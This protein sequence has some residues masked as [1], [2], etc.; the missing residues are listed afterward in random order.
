MAP[1]HR[2]VTYKLYP[3]PGQA[4]GDRA[5]L[6]PAPGLVQRGAGGADRGIPQGGQVDRL[7]RPVQIRD[8]IRRD[9]L[10]Y[11]GLNAQS[12][13]VT[14]K[15]L[16]RAFQSFFRRVKAGQT[17]GFPRFKGRDRFPGFG[18]KHHGDGFRF[19][20]GKGWKHGTLRLSG[21]G[22]MS[23]RGEARTPGEVVCA[24]IQRK[25]NGWHPASSSRASRTA[26]ARA[27]PS[28][29]SIGVWRRMPRSAYGPFQFEEI[30]NDRFLAAEQ[31]SLKAEQ[32]VLSRALRGKRSK[33]A[34]KARKLLAHRSRRLAN[35]R[36]DRTHQVTA[37]LVRDHALIVTEDLRITNVMA[38]AKGTV[39][40]PGKRLYQVPEG[41]TRLGLVGLRQV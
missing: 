32:R 30:E 4:V 28:R 15:R 22:E 36:K 3:S 5:R 41:V 26:S 31:N 12:L 21:V 10:A 6:R 20:P 34:A 13:Q 27:T 29:V 1:V 8:V 9:D 39:A 25:A 24:D 18:F 11:R 38:S 37:W 17:P 19:T 33:R 40:E 14:L 7:C 23:A 16:D 2:R 35:R